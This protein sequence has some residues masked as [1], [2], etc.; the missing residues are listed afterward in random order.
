[1]RR[2][3]NPPSYANRALHLTEG[4]VK[5]YVSHGLAKL[6]LEHRTQAALLAVRLGIDTEE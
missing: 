2:A 4:I 6:K 5:G 3:H 1:V